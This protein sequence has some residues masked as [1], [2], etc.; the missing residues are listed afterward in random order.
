MSNLKAN[1]LSLSLTNQILYPLVVSVRCLSTYSFCISL[2]V[3]APF[4]GTFVTMNFQA[5][6]SEY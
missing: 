4:T 1:E 3:I 2:N 6:D 5:V